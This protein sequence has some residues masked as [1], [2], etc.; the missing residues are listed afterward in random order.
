MIDDL[1]QETILDHSKRPRNHHALADAR[2]TRAVWE[3]LAELDPNRGERWV[4]RRWDY[5]PTD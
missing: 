5:E 3:H 1:Y 4:R 2:W